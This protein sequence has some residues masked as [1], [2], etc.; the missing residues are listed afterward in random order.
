MD[1]HFRVHQRTTEAEKR[2]THRSWYVDHQ[3]WLRS[4]EIV[5]SDHVAPP[6]EGREQTAE[7]E[8]EP[9]YIP[10]PDPSRG[11]SN[12]CPICQEKF[13]NKWLDTAQEWV[14]LDA[15]LVG[16][17]AFHAS[18]HA[19]AARDREGTP[20]FPRR[21]PEPVLGKRKADSSISSVKVRTLKTSV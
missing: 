9:Q 14:W 4:R 19:E 1:W 13:E 12:V 16:N 7:D 18:C 11:I 20:G 17:R 15:I 5:D 8:G 21:T 6:D 2:G 3:E 10:V